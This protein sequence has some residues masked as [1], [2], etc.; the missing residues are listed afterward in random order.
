M[1]RNRG[2]RGK[3]G[4]PGFPEGAC[5]SWAREPR[6]S[7]VTRHWM[8]LGYSLAALIAAPPLAA[9]AEEAQSNEAHKSPG[10]EMKE[11][12][13]AV[14]HATRDSGKAIGRGAKTA[15]KGIASGAKNAGKEIAKGARQIGHGV[16]DAVKGQ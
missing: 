15:G 6:E 4:P 2:A 8:L 13:R 1:N 5:Y 9:A 14:G 12:G 7:H 10:A 3:R 11:A 16:R